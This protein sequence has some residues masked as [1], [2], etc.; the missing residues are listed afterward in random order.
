MPMS[1]IDTGLKESLSSFRGE[2]CHTT[3]WHQ[4][5]CPLPVGADAVV[6]VVVVSLCADSHIW[7]VIGLILMD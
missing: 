5:R 3:A 4:R 2:W 7:N 1:A 6:V